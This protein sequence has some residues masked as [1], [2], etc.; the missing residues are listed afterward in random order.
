VI[1][2]EVF[3]DR[4]EISNPG[5]LV[6]AIPAS[7]FGKRSHSRNPLV[8]GL[9]ARMHLVEQVG[10]GIGRIQELMLAAN[11]PEPVFLK[12]GMFTVVLRRSVESR[13]KSRVESRVKSRVKIL[14]LMRE[15]PNVTI[16][17]LAR[18]IGI[19]VKAIEKQIDILKQEGFIE[20]EGPRKG[21]YW[22][23]IKLY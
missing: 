16:P 5:G 7:E 12:E 13:V 1:H 18:E 3:S 8:F 4:V 19:T 14:S 21:G 22:K 17:M 20:R 23:I 11:L 10:S 15:N 2:V 6:S 9:F